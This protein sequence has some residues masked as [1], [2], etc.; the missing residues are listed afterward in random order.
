M[1]IHRQLVAFTLALMLF[2]I[3]SNGDKPETFFKETFSNDKSLSKWAVSHFRGDASWSLSKFQ[4][5]QKTKTNDGCARLSIHGQGYIVDSFYVTL[6]TIPRGQKRVEVTF[7]YKASC[8]LPIFISISKNYGCMDPFIREEKT[9]IADGQWHQASIVLDLTWMPLSTRVLEFL[10]DNVGLNNAKNDD[11]VLIDDVQLSAY[12]P[13][14][15]KTPMAYWRSPGSKMLIDKTPSQTIILDLINPVS[16]ACSFDIKIQS[17]ETGKIVSQN[18]ESV[19][20][21]EKTIQI[22][23]KEFPVGTYTVS[24][25]SAGAKINSWQFKKYPYRD[26]SVLIHDG[27]P[28]MNGKPF[29]VLGLYHS[30]DAVIEIVNGRSYKVHP[31][32]V[33]SGLYDASASKYLEKSDGWTRAKLF[34]D[35]SDRGFNTVFYSWG[36]APKSYFK[37]ADQYG[38]KVVCE[39]QSLF[40]QIDKVKDQPNILGWYGLDEAT[41]HMAAHC[42]DI[43]KQYKE[44]DPY[45]PVMAAF[46]FG[47]AGYGNYRM[48]DMV[49]P[50]PYPFRSAT[51]DFGL[52]VKF[53][54]DTDQESLLRGDP[55]NCIVYVPQLFTMDAIMGGYAPSYDQIRAEVYTAIHYGAKGIFY[56][57]LF[58]H[59]PLS[60]GMPMNPDRKYWFL[61]EHPLWNEIGKLNHELMAIKDVI[62][63]GKVDP[64][65]VIKSSDAVL[66]HGLILPEKQQYILLVNTGPELQKKVQIFGL[67]ASQKLSAQFQSPATRLISKGVNSVDLKGYGVGIY[68]VKNGDSAVT[69]SKQ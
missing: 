5:E 26:N 67:K 4:D 30:S 65:I 9:L 42:A 19:T 45:H 24:V 52:K 7:R 68:L 40:D 53:H 25:T 23:T 54:M 57:A 50:D 31:A 17:V 64:T 63:L 41:P 10:V 48:V 49:M 44:H 22:D 8:G 55:T 21:D 43:Y 37:D 1:S 28:Y 36:V 69:A 18:K 27:V 2:P 51:T 62:L 29:L 15:P 20:A 16:G 12:V 13:A 61:P 66:G 3:T 38:L 56:Y 14:K 39:S 60:K 46:C 58:T 59:E 33:M 11:F 6:P 35:L 47:G 32:A 34:K